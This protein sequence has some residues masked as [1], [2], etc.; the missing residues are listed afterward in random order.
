MGSEG[1]VSR[2]S[3][4]GEETSKP[5]P[6]LT[7]PNE[8]LLDIFG[9]VDDIKHAHHDED[10]GCWEP[11]HRDD[12]AINDL[13]SCRLTCR[14]FRD[15][16]SELLVRTLRIDYHESS[17]E[18]LAEISRHPTVSL[19]VR[20]IKI[21]L[22]TYE[23]EANYTFET[24]VRKQESHVRL[25]NAPAGPEYETTRDRTAHDILDSWHRIGHPEE[26]NEQPQDSV[27]RER[28]LALYQQ[29]EQL[30]RGQEALRK[31]GGFV[32]AIASAV[33]RMPRVTD[34]CVEHEGQNYS[35]TWFNESP[36]KAEK[37]L[38]DAVLPMMRTRHQPQGTFHPAH[39]ALPKILTALCDA[40]VPLETLTIS[41]SPGFRL[42]HV[43]MEDEETQ[44]ATQHVEDSSR[45]SSLR[46]LCVE[47]EATVDEEA[48]IDLGR[49]IPFDLYTGLTDLYLCTERGYF[50]ES[51][52]R[53]F[54]SR[55]P[56]TLN[57]LALGARLRGRRFAE[58]LDA[59]RRITFPT[60]KLDID[61]WCDDLEEFP[62]HALKYIFKK[63]DERDEGYPDDRDESRPSRAVEYVLRRSDVNPVREVLGILE[64]YDDMYED[65]DSD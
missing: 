34:L 25:A 63:R 50:N 4:G 27:H 49:L 45:T 30:C 17:I 9:H 40:R 59:M 47:I 23:P 2:T 46:K 6:I 22:D 43:N 61:I 35:P 8:T 41:L 19:G 1:E 37:A 24:F 53:R 12:L 36:A 38:Y 11:P 5:P 64:G 32:A 65:I 13:W 56:P 52:S 42:D 18:R 10:L 54:L 16:S 57:S 14:R 15:V 33:A 26:L 62:S 39:G 58:V 20:T 51:G 44:A 21:N 48:A 55:L 7:L 3:H 60:G 31:R 28:L 29:H